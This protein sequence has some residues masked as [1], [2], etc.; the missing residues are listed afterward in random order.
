MKKI[1][2]ILLSIGMSLGVVACG[3]K[4]K[5]EVPKTG[6]ETTREGKE[7]QSAKE[8]KKEENIEVDT[9]LLS[10]E[11]TI[12]ASFYES[13]GITPSEEELSE[14]AKNEKDTEYIINEDGSVTCKMSKAAYKKKMDE[15]LAGIQKSID[16]ILNDKETYPSILEIVTNDD[17]SEITVKTTCKSKDELSMDENMIGFLISISALPYHIYSKEQ[18][19]KIVVNYVNSD[20]GDLIYTYDSSSE[21]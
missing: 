8:E 11:I 7:E 14:D 15:F 18:P 5:T 9:H 21:E 1:L 2:V 16:D 12:P 10:V 3:E 20:T 19:E 6:Q 13:L 4:E 17:Y